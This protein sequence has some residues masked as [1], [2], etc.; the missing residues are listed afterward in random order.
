MNAA[1][2]RFW[3]TLILTVT[4]IA[5]LSACHHSSSAAT[6]SYAVY[7]AVV[8]LAGSGLVLQNN[9]GNNLSVSANGEVNFSNKLINGATYDV[10][11]LTQPGGPVQVCSVI[12]GTGLVNGNNV[13]VEVSCGTVGTAVG[14]FAYVANRGSNTVSA[15]AINATTGALTE[16]TGSPFKVP[17]AKQ[18]YQTVIDPS[19]SYLYAVDVSGNQLFG[20]VINQNTG[21]LSAIPG[22][23]FATGRQPVSLTFDYSGSFVYVA[24][25]TDGTISGYALTFASGLL[26]PLAAS[27]FAVPG[28]APG[29][30]QIARSGSFLFVANEA[31]SNIAV[32][33]IAASTGTLAQGIPGSPFATDTGPHSLAIGSAG[34]N[35]AVLYT[36]NAGASNAG[37]ISAFTV[38]LATG[39]LSPVAGN[40]QPIP[41]VNNV[42]I[43]TRAKFLFVTETAGV[44]VYPIVNVASG[45][46][47]T[48]VSG[49]PFA[50]GTN[51]YSLV[52]DVDDLFAYVGNDGSGSISQFTFSGTSGVLTPVAGAPLVLAGANPDYLQIQ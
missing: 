23:P 22:S 29:P 21:A 27:P 50:T 15:Y 10:T 35:S 36:A 14:R 52:T 25:Y 33:S 31:A 5:T 47:G 12:Q 2:R 41:V 6:T 32:F 13:L 44:S 28:T 26:T 45:L 48:P 20:A 17:G 19:G 51:P 40:P 8:G 30:R 24:N 43:D 9:G 3:Q 39:V 34:S 46:L 37:S 16:V 18:L 4:G 11:V 42:A 1:F 7:V 49:S 38:D